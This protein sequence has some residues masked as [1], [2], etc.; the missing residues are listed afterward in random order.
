MALDRK[1]AYI[2]LSTG[3]VTIKPIPLEMRKKYIGSRGVDAYFH[4]KDPELSWF[5]EINLSG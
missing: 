2:D 4:D 3:K 5:Q 1:I